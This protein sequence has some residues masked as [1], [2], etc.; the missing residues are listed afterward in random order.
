MCIIRPVIIVV[1][2]ALA[3]VA[4]HA[5]HGDGGN[6]SI[7][8]ATAGGG[9]AGGS[10]TGSAGSPTSASAAATLPYVPCATPQPG[11]GGGCGPGTTSLRAAGPNAWQ[12]R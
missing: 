6:S 2:V 8:G 12:P 11:H 4:A 3:P 1:C 9:P 10:T 5:G 7:V